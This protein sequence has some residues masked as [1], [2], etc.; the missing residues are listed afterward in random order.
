MS[1]YEKC[2]NHQKVWL[3][4]TIM[5]EMKPCKNCNKPFEAKRKNSYFCSPQCNANY[6]F[7]NK[8][9]YKR[10]IEQTTKSNI[11]VNPAYFI[12]PIKC[13]I[14]NHDHTELEKKIGYKEIYRCFCC[15]NRFAKSYSGLDVRK[16]DMIA[17]EVKA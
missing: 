15:N 14:C 7:K 16:G 1:K 12:K 6:L 4:K 9:K 8:L 13:P 3:P 17:I 11:E 10:A 5:V 2:T